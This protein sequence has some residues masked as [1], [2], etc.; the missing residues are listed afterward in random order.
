MNLEEHATN[1]S[2]DHLKIYVFPEDW[3]PKLLIFESPVS[4]MCLH[5]EDAQNPGTVE[6]N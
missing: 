2:L 4:S 3:A 1:L 5:S 6:I